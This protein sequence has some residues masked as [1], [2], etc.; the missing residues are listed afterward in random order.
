MGTNYFYSPRPPCA[1]CGRHFDELHI[2]K[3]SGGWCFALHVIPD[4][5]INSLDDW[6]AR[7]ALPGS[8]IQNEYGDV[9]TVEEMLSIITERER[10]GRLPLRHDPVDGRHCIG[11][12]EGTWDLIAGEF[13]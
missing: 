11:H 6:K 3:S 10:Q 2:G 4:E 13:S 12:G 8:S 7:F 5:G 1:E 9:T